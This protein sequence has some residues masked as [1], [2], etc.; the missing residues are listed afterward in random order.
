MAYDDGFAIIPG[1]PVIAPGPLD[2]SGPSPREMI[3][4]SLSPHKLIRLETLRAAGMSVGRVAVQLSIQSSAVE[5]YFSQRDQ[6]DAIRN[7]SDPRNIGGGR[8]P[9]LSGGGPPTHR[10]GVMRGG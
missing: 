9:N 4:R 3:I 5:M 2:D 1:D 7:N 10:P 6:F 8:I